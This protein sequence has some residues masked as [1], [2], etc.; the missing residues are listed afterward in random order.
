LPFTGLVVEGIC[1]SEFGLNIGLCAL[2]EN[3]NKTQ[4]VYVTRIGNKK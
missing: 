2:E 1:G 4:K 3:E